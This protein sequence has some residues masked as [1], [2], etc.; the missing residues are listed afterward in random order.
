MTI[1]EK[2]VPLEILGMSEGDAVVGFRMTEGSIIFQVA[3]AIGDR[4]QRQE[5]RVREWVEK[6]GGSMKLEAG[7]SRESLRS[8]AMEQ[9]FG[10]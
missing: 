10:S 1:V 2:A 4:P 5:R 9:K 3:E 6:W 8:A 7:E